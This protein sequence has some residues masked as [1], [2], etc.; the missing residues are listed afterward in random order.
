MGK[1][2]SKAWLL[3]LMLLTLAM[4]IY[5]CGGPD[6]EETEKSEKDET[7]MQEN[8]TYAGI[9]TYVDE[10]ELHVL[11][12][13]MSPNNKMVVAILS[14]GDGRVFYAVANEG[15]QVIE[16]SRL[17]LVTEEVDYSVGAEYIEGEL[18]EV[19]DEYTLLNGKHKGQIIDTCNQYTFTLKKDSKELIVN[20][21]IYD[22]G[23]AYSYAMEEGATIIK[24][25]SEAVFAEEASLWVYSQPNVTYEGSYRELP[26]K[27]VY[28]IGAKYSI[29]SLLKT[30]DSWVLLTEASVFD[31]QESYCSSYLTKVANSR[32]LMWTFGNGQTEAVVMSDAF[33]TPWRTAIISTDLNTL[34][35]SDMVTSLC[36]D[37]YDTDFSF[38]KPGKLAWSWWSS[39]GDD[40]IDYE[41]QY[42]YID[43]AAENGWDY[44][45][46]DYGWVLWEDYQTKVKEIVDYA[47]KKNIGI[48]L[49]YGVNDSG[50]AATGS[51]PKYSLLNEETIRT[52][53]EWA[54]SIGIK[55]VKVDYYESDNQVT[56][57]QMY[58]CAK[59]AAECE[60]MVLF[61]GCTN[62]G[63]EN[64][65]FPNILSYEAVY[66]AEY[67]KWRTEPSMSN[68]IT[69]LF[70]RNVV[71]SSDFTPTALPVAGVD[72]TYGFMLGTTI[73]IESGLVH[74]AENVNV[75]EGYAGLSLMNDIPVSWDE[76]IVLE[77]MPGKYGT[78]VRRLEQEWYLAA[79][80]VE[81]RTVEVSLSF[82]EEGDAYT[83]YIYKTNTAGDNIEVITQ[84]VTNKDT[85]TV[86]LG[87]SDG[88]SVKLT[89]E[90]FDYVTDYEKEYIYLEGEKASLGGAAVV[91]GSAF[92]DQ[93]ASGQKTA[94]YIGNGADNSVTFYTTVEKAGVYE[95][96]LFYISA[97]DR[98]FM[99]SINGDD[100][101]RIRTAKLNSGDW[102][103]VKK[104]TL[105][106]ELEAGE[107]SIKFYNDEAFA[108]NL[109]RISLSKQ[110]VDAEAS[111]SDEEADVVVV[112][113]GA[114]YTYNLYEAESG[115]IANGATNE[116]TLV[117]WLGGTAYVEL[118]NI[119]VEA[120]G[121]YY[122]QI[123]YMTGE[124]RKVSLSVNG[125]ENMVVDCPSSGDYYSNPAC[126]YVEVEL[127]AGKNT[128]RFSNPSGYAPN[129]DK[130]GISTTVVE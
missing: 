121:T 118:N 13:I 71:G 106:V 86:E 104:E 43:F 21:R 32:S 44:V 79:L 70:T 41:V 73:Y 66:G 76:T 58:L 18:C 89:R 69:Y 12:T 84:E 111:V 65:T 126:A 92:N 45:C 33:E 1:K 9:S 52:E 107:N 82:L 116:G 23:I 80:T 16:P 56:M 110:V 102:V 40:P 36:E 87:A 115:I 120:A 64:R 19:T 8:V 109:D 7:E 124:D 98:R 91:S 2:R 114:Q 28:K 88:C 3:L 97:N 47:D 4:G 99:I 48:W 10:T 119:E 37:V 57:E 42:D 85:L 96:N 108:P 38:V 35:N 50:H 95:L 103:T 93:Y 105:Y 59:I 130:I 30:G 15:A 100:S 74:F 129:L 22:E 20:M 25:A 75:Y 101:N 81:A 53:F 6:K 39:T 62:P 78:V 61:H 5:G 128:I 94:E 11:K 49:W 46:L 112:S 127:N 125:G 34:V 63:G 113:P 83:A 27:N 14:A 54:K 29:P 68:I 117:G 17:G 55:G 31:K 26:M 60:Q 67:Y 122:V 90:E 123:W 77:G 72:A 24:E 51:Y